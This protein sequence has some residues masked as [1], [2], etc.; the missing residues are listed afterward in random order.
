M[1]RAY[2]AYRLHTFRSRMHT[3]P[4]QRGT[5]NTKTTPLRLTAAASVVALAVTLIGCAGAEQP[6][7]AADQSRPHA[8]SHSLTT[9]AMHR[10]LLREA[11]ERYVHGQVVHARMA[12]EEAADTG[13]HRVSER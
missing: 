9:P 2:P 6:A 4:A 1:I 11:A 13:V 8:A 5:M 12:A 10:A 7:P 3:C